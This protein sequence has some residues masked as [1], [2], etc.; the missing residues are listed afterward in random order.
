MIFD[1][2]VI[3]ELSFNR[4]KQIYEKRVEGERIENGELRIE[5]GKWR[6]K[7]TGYLMYCFLSINSRHRECLYIPPGDKIAQLNSDVKI[8]LIIIYL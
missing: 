7:G 4:E 5:N 8:I 2:L 3:P 6:I 1:F